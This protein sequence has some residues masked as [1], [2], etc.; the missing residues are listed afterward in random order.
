MDSR[1]PPLVQ[2]ELVGNG[3]TVLGGPNG[4]NLV[5]AIATR[6][7]PKLVFRINHRV[8]APRVRDPGQRR[9]GLSVTS[10]SRISARK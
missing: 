3:V 5:F 4:P 7:V 1:E 6:T 8:I 9:E 10:V 2:R